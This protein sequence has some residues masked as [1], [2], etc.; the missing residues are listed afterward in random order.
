MPA[1]GQWM[2][3]PN[4]G[5]KKIPLAAQTDI[6]KRIQNVA[7]EQFQDRYPRLDIRFRSQ[8]C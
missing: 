2:F 7:Q 1:R 4:S 6:Q 8:F 3:D 5:G